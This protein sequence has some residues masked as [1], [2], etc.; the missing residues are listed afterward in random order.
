MMR[1]TNSNFGGEQSGHILMSDY[2]A[3]GD[4][5]VAALQ[6]LAILCQN[7]GLAR[8][9][10]LNKQVHSNIQY[11][12]SN[13]LLMSDAQH[14]I[15]SITERFQSKARILVRS[16]GTERLIRIMVEFEGEEDPSIMSQL[17]I[18]LLGS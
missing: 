15:Q 12:G 1:Q 11:S 7:K 16:S 5:I 8:P 18:A 6:L 14:Q 4:G 13:P 10:I 9:F 3:T 2:A 17:K